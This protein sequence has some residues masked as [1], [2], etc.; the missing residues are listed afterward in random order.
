MRE[1]CQRPTAPKVT[2]RSQ[3]HLQEP[4]RTAKHVL[5]CVMRTWRCLA[6]T[7]LWGMRLGLEARGDPSILMNYASPLIAAALTVPLR[8]CSVFG[9]RQGARLRHFTLFFISPISSIYGFGELLIKASPLV[10]IAMGLAIGFRANVWNI[11]AE[12]QLTVGAI[13]A[14]GIALTLNETPKS[15]LVAC[16]DRRRCGGRHELGG[17]P[18]VPAHPASTPTRSS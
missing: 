1:T 16:N 10:L 12:G 4:F 2:S 15:A 14:S 9:A 17:D 13:A 18:G 8:T 5:D 11:G 6:R 7:K 3:G